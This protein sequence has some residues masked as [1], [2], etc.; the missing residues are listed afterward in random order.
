MLALPA[1][2]LAD[3]EVARPAW[4]SAESL[5]TPESTTSLLETP[6]PRA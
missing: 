4:L 1:L 5:H 2:M 3:T 6:P